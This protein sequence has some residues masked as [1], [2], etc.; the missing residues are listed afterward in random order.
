VGK[1]VE[2]IPVKS[3]KG[4]SKCGNSK[5]LIT[6]IMVDTYDEDDVGAVF[7]DHLV[8]FYISQEAAGFRLWNLNLSSVTYYLA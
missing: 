6:A 3:R 4:L 1:K 8:T 5:K 2:G 7:P